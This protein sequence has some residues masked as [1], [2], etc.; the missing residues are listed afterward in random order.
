MVWSARKGTL[1]G[2]GAP[3]CAETTERLGGEHNYGC[4]TC[5]ES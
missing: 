3:N 2:D 4:C 5:G 1:P